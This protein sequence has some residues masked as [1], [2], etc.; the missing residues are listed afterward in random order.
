VNRI[1]IALALFLAC[2]GAVSAQQ[3]SPAPPGPA[4]APSPKKPPANDIFSGTVT[5]LT[6]DSVTVLRTALVREAV[7][8]TFVLDSQTVVE[9]NLRVKARVSVRY[10]ADDAGQFHALHII[11]R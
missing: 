5:E 6:A 1:A 9:G 10:M 11:V 2:P 3:D 7:K 4:P 8:R